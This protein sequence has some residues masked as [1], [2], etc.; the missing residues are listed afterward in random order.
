MCVFLLLFESA[1]APPVFSSESF[2]AD[3]FRPSDTKDEA[4]AP[5]YECLNFIRD[6]LCRESLSS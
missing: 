6:L 3:V 2:T 1:F 4:Q 5:I